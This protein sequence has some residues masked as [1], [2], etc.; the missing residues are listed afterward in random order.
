MHFFKMLK[1]TFVKRAKFGIHLNE[2]RLQVLFDICKF[3]SVVVVDRDSSK[4]DVIDNA[5]KQIT[6]RIFTK[7]I[8]NKRDSR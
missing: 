3:F 1:M 2:K 8:P 6:H 5:I 7:L 4:L